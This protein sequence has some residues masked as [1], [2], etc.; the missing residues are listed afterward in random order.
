MLSGKI[1]SLVTSQ[2]AP[3]HVWHHLGHNHATGSGSVTASVTFP[4]NK[5]HA[6]GFPTA[7][8][9]AVTP[10]QP[11]AASVTNQ[12]SSGFDVTLTALDGGA[13]A[14]GSFMLLVLG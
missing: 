7:Y 2:D 5:A 12:T 8:T 3:A 14:E 1:N 6:G 11:C 4:K 13:L 10:S 9:V